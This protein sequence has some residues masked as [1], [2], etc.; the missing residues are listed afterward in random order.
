[1]FK[2]FTALFFIFFSLQVLSAGSAVESMVSINRYPQNSDILEDYLFQLQTTPV[3]DPAINGIL[4]PVIGFPA[5]VT[6][7]EPCF[8]VIFR[9]TGDPGIEYL[10][11]VRFDEGGMTEYLDLGG[12]F[13]VE[14]INAEAKIGRIMVCNMFL[15]EAKYDIVLKLHGEDESVSRNA[16]FFPHYEENDPTKFLI[17]ADPQL[18][19]L[20]SKKTDD[21]NFNP[22]NYP[23]HADKS[24]L[25]YEQQFGIT[26][27]TFSQLNSAVCNFTIMLG[28]IVYG[29]DFQ[30]EYSDFYSLMT[31]LEVPMFSIPGN[32]DGYTHF[33]KVD[34]MTSPLE[35]D[36]LEYWAKFFGPKNNA[37][38]F[39]NKT[40]LLLNT[41]DGTPKRRASSQI[42]IGDTAASPVAN[43]GGYLAEKTLN[44][45]ENVLENY[46]VAAVF[47]HMTPLGQDGTGKYHAN[48]AFSKIYGVVSV[49]DEQEWNFD[50]ASWDSDESDGILNETQKYNNGILLASF[51]TKKAKPPV[52]FSGHTHHDKIFTFEKGT[53]LLENVNV[54]LTAPEKMEFIMT[55]T[56]ATSGSGKYWGFRR[57]EMSDDK[58][59]YNYTCERFENCGIDSSIRGMQSVPSG[60]LWVDY[61]WKNGSGNKKSIFVGGDGSASSVKAGITNYLPTEEEVMLRFILPATKTGYKL[62]NENFKFVDA[63]VS[64][65]LS[66]VIIIV[67][68][69]IAAG[70]ALDSFYERDFTETIDF[71]TISPISENQEAP[72]PDVDFPE[73]IEI[74][75]SG[76]SG[77]HASVKNHEYFSTLI[78]RAEINGKFSDFASGESVDMENIVD[79]LGNPAHVSLRYTTP[80]GISGKLDFTA[81]IEE[82]YDCCAETGDE[83]IPDEETVEST[84]DEEPAQESGDPGSEIPENP[85]KTEKKSGSGCSTIIL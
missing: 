82:N 74:T 23:F 25:D 20:L 19:D 34:D 47:G 84:P 10:K 54:D 26:K 35:S 83:D 57:V 43:W 71:V 32:H 29:T 44:W 72:V 53:K 2:R 7:D 75:D 21:M 18:G 14:T 28:D 67:K 27:A 33:M 13:N 79:S 51:L 59:S 63:V 5:M 22:E 77:T 49:I 73:K 80:D 52:Y 70:S 16:L 4:Y 3:I 61:S 68:G 60:N 50:S 58:I 37:F 48:R 6:P 66:K 62:D 45:A 1:M 9:Y 17:V 56:M 42:G 40:Y 78:W 69:S 55:T 8:S 46:D 30:K 85:A 24:L 81:E 65:D 64:S 11:V 76:I 15:P 38:S 41:Y 31:D 36:G 39:R 12:S